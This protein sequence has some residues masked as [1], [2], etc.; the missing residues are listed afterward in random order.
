M[1]HLIL[2][3]RVEKKKIKELKCGKYTFQKK[4][5]PLHIFREFH[6]FSSDITDINGES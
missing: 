6:D 3:K 5:G 1:K 2:K 4:E